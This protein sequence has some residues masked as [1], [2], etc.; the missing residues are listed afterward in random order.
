MHDP[1]NRKIGFIGIALVKGR[2]Y[3]D[4]QSWKTIKIVLTKLLEDNHYFQTDKF[5]WIGMDFRYGTENNLKVEFSRINKTYGD[6]CVAIELDMAI[7]QWADK[8]NLTL[9]HDIFMIATLEAL[10]QVCDKYKLPKDAIIE[11]RKK[12]SQIPNTIEECQCYG[13]S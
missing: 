5:L 12:Y 7:L 3:N 2:L 6:L 10:L 4:M 11:E 9:L 13:N 1:F 8:N